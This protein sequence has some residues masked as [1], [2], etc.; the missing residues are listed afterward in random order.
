MQPEPQPETILL[1]EDDPLA[2]KMGEM[3]LNRAGYNVLSAMN[4]FLGLKLAREEHPDL[5]L[6]DLM[7]PGMDGFEILS[8]LRANP[9]TAAIPVLILSAKTREEDKQMASRIGA[10]GY[11][12][13][14]YHRAELLDQMHFLLK[15]KTQNILNRLTGERPSQGICMAFVSPQGDE[16]TSVALKAGMALAREGVSVTAVDFRPYSIEHALTLDLT[17]DTDEIPASNLTTTEQVSAMSLIHESGLRLLHNLNGRGRAGQLT[18]ADVDRLLDTILSAEGIV[19]ADIPL[20][21]ADVFA[22]VAERCA[23]TFLV[24]PAD[25]IVMRSAQTTFK[26]IQRAGVSAENIRF[27]IIGELPQSELERMG[28]LIAA[29]IPLG[30]A[31][32]DPAFQTLA[33]L[34][35]GAGK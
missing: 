17:P 24:I 33:E 34:M 10:N 3:I 12:T 13:K 6:L 26:L 31:A 27:I 21:P 5:I 4:G 32:S 7:L 16:A 35:Q 14:P 23:Q 30:A 22:R 19:I 29:T 11:M 28:R 25:P 15:E 9:A 18:Q 8:R 2:V 20:Y 1:I